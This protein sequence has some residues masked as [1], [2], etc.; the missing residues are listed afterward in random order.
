MKPMQEIRK[1][2]HE[3]EGKEFLAT[4]LKHIDAYCRN[5]NNMLNSGELREA[6]RS[7]IKIIYVAT[8]FLRPWTYERFPFN[9]ERAARKKIQKKNIVKVVKP[10]KNKHLEGWRE[11]C[12]WMFQAPLFKELGK[13]VHK[14]DY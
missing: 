2:I 7:G 4:D 6:G 1:A 12:P 3:L 5:L 10:A 13:R 8:E 11:T 14:P 9:P